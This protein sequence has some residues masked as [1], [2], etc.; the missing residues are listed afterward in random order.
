MDLRPALALALAAAAV[1]AAA[2]PDRL[3][4]QSVVTLYG[5]AAPLLESVGGSNATLSRPAGATDLLPATAYGADAPVRRVRL[6]SNISHLGVR[7]SESL[8]GG[9]K[10]I[11]QLEVGFLV[12]EVRAVGFP[13]RNSAIGVAGPYGQVLLGQWDT[14]F[15]SSTIAYGP[16]RLGITQDFPT[17]MSNP[18]FGV[19]VLTTQPTR[20]GGKADAAFDRRQGNSIQYWSPVLSG[21]QARLLYSV[22]E[23]RGAATAGGPVVDPKVFGASLT[24]GPLGRQVGA[25]WERHEDYFGMSQVAGS[26]AGTATNP[27]SRDEA[28]KLYGEMKLG[29]VRVAAFADRI[30]YRNHDSAVGAIERYRRD[31]VNL[32]VQP[33]VGPHRPWFTWT[34]ANA[35]SCSRVGGGSCGTSG[36]GATQVTAGWLYAFSKR[37]EVYVVAQWLK[38]EPSATYGTLPPLAAPVPGARYTAAGVG[39]SHFF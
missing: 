2:A 34:R 8:G 23:G 32:L 36:L 24:W 12:D 19:P 9:W 27:S 10:A 38:N 1:P 7:G 29:P 31:A 22:N 26:P 35:G 28:F 16:M 30:E 37:T 21:I 11:F 25:S 4:E 5:L 15:K 18:G 20:I 13:D 6:G 14:P 33:I 3:E 39:M 17:L